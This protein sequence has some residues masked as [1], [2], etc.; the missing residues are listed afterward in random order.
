MQKLNSFDK[1]MKRFQKITREIRKEL[2]FHQDAETWKNRKMIKQFNRVR[3]HRQNVRRQL[4]RES[5][6]GDY[7]LHVWKTSG[8]YYLHVRKK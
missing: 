6:L 8:R 7:E 4:K 1:K 3:K 5:K 2:F